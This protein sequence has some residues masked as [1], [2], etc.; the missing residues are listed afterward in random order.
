M[1]EVEN[2]ISSSS[3][4][5][6]NVSACTDQLRKEQQAVNDEIAAKN[7][8]I[9]HSEAEIHRRN[10]MTER[11]QHL[12]DQYNKKLEAMIC[13]AGVRDALSSL[14]LLSSPYLSHCAKCFSHTR[15]CVATYS[16]ACRP[17]CVY[18]CDSWFLYLCVSAMTAGLTLC[19][20]ARIAL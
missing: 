17:T 14:V 8:I 7:A 15:E 11:K 10:I 19:D 2:S 3:L 18:V 16:A 1:C 6:V 9:S 20:L 12:I 4:S 5:A 13:A